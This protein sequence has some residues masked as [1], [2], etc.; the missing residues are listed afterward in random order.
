VVGGGA[1]SSLTRELRGL[2][3]SCNCG[4]LVTTAKLLAAR[5]FSVED[6]GML[7]KKN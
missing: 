2:V 6:L 7:S 3:F 5:V 4:S 1:H